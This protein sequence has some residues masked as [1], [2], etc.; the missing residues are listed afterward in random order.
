MTVSLRHDWELAEIEALL[1]LPLVDLL[2]QAQQV[3]REANPGYQVQLASLLSVRTGGCEEDCAYCPQSMHNSSDVSGRPQLELQVAAVL[4]RAK[5]AKEA[6]AQ[7][8]CMGWAWREIRDGAPFEAM[9]EMVAGVKQ[10]GME[11]CVTAGM[12][13]NGQANRLAQAGLTSYNHNLDTSP[14]YYAEI[15]STR[16]YQDRI[17]TLQR[18]RKAGI[19]LCCGGIIGMGETL[20]DRASMLQV[21][22]NLDPQPESVPING[23][24]AVEGTPL[25]N[26]QPYESLDLLRMVA[27]A[28]ILM[29]HSRVRLSAGREQLNQ[30]AQILCLLAGADSIFYGDTLLTTSN[31]A[32]EADRA[33][34]AAAG[35]QPFSIS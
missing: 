4:E 11:A 17:E 12:L 9:L 8:F 25:E 19:S 21:L 22:A 20:K 10:L 31:P 33:L 35:V 6:G 1:N 14:E 7:R 30:E 24:V 23:L 2:W 3:H 34:L 15:I 5:A 28:R 16:T 13:S 26:Q 27:T 18:V 29:P 32:V